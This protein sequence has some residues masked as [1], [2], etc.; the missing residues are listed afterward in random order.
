MVMV[1]EY[2]L[3][4]WSVVAFIENRIHEKIDYTELE[5]ATGFS[6][7]HIRDIFVRKTGITLSRYILTRKIAN[8]AYEI[9]HNNQN[10]LNI[11]TKYGFTNHDTFTRAFKRITGL[12]P[13]N[14]RIKRPA[15]GRIKLCA[16]VYGIGLLNLVK[17][18]DD[19]L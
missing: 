1:M 7:A 5:K 13:T 11:A 2:F 4:L 8:A 17:R 14:F 16:G 15:L 10:I 12:T 18:E 19:K 3:T 9:L 6:L